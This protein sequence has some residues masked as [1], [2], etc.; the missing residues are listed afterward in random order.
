MSNDIQ[1]KRPGHEAVAVFAK[2]LSDLAMERA[3]TYWADD[4]PFK[5]D[6]RPGDVTNE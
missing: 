3:N 4:E 5:A 6:D 1:I 2:N